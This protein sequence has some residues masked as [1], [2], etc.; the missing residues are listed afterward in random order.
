[1][2]KNNNIIVINIARPIIFTQLAL[3]PIAAFLRAE[4]QF[5]TPSSKSTAYQIA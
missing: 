4:L 3:E 1:M 2:I 5:S